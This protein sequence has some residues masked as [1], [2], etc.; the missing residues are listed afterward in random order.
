M[1]TCSSRYPTS[2]FPRP[3]FLCL[4]N[5]IRSLPSKPPTSFCYG[6]T[7]CS[8]DPLERPSPRLGCV[9]CGD[10]GR[11]GLL[12]TWLQT[13][14]GL[15]EVQ[16]VHAL[17]L[18]CLGLADSYTSNNLI[19]GYVRYGMTDEARKVFDEIPHWG[20]NVVTWTT[21][22]NGYVRA[23]L[24]DE[25]LRLFL[26][27]VESGVRPNCK[28][29][30]CVLNLCSKRLDVELGRQVHASLVKYGRRNLLVDSAVVQLYGRCGELDGAFCMFDQMHEHDVVSWTT[31]ITAC[32][33]SGDGKAALS[34]FARM[35]NDR[36]LPN[37]HTV[38]SVLN[39]CG[40]VGELK[41]GKQ[42]HGRIVRGMI[43]NDIFVWTA[44]VDMY[45]KCGEMTNCWKVFDG[46]RKRNT[47]TWT[48]IIA[49]YAKKGL[50]E[51][52][53]NLFREMKKR[54]I[55]ANEM[56][57]VSILTACG[58][59]TDLRLGAEVHAAMIKKS[60]R[61]NAYLGS[62]LVWFYCKCG[63][64]TTASSVLQQLPSRDVVS[65][66]AIIS[67]CTKL[68]LDGEALERLNDMIQEGVEP[69]TFTYSSALKACAKLETVLPGK[70]LHS[71]ANKNYLSSD[72]YVGSSLV[73]MYAKCG[74]VNEA[75]QVFDRMPERNLVT[76][77]AMIMG[78]A[79]NGLTQEALKLMFRLREEGVELD[80]YVVSTVLS[81]CGDV[82]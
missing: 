38:C 37:E 53:I 56:T 32:S 67:G 42:L 77:K 50:G 22:V 16:M 40:E 2:V 73:H 29:Y 80:D 30:V 39:A 35:L 36:L 58:S 48:S 54:N 45:A 27:A 25:A 18:K 64:Y 15:K 75:A 3:P 52:A 7:L 71:S 65:W 81:S 62:A 31:I 1:L 74:H 23:R 59:L 70:L 78:Y 6:T 49:G 61:M 76:L 66:T 41:V 9:P 4:P 33:K 8:V 69:N 60:T 57:A 14:H 46:M 28:T 51:A 47:V 10:F 55:Y 63:K 20:R 5:P 44:L 34:M 19:S 12:A 72:V 82:E 24:E 11:D 43:N 17:V 21:M 68:G 79:R 13:C 26:N